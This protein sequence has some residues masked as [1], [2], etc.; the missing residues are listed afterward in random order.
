MPAI[1]LPIFDQSLFQQP[2]EAQVKQ[3]GEFIMRYR[4][5]LE[6]L[7]NGRLD[8][9]NGLSGTV[10]VN[11]LITNNLVT[12]TLYANGKAYIAELTVDQIDTSDMVKRY[13]LPVGH[14]LRLA[15]VGYWRGY[16]QFIEFL[17]AQIPDPDNLVEVQVRDRQDRLVYWLD[18]DHIGTGITYENTGLPVMRFVY[19]GPNGVGLLKLAIFHRWNADTKTFNP[20][21]RLGAGTGVGNNGTCEIEKKTDG[22]YMT[23][24]A[25]GSGALSAGKEVLLALTDNGV[26]ISPFQLEA[27]AF[28]S[29]GFSVTYSGETM[30]WTWTK[31]GAGKITSLTNED[32]T[33]PVTWG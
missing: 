32:G 13:L 3:L 15:P 7:L 26:I 10:N 8:E 12:E 1:R 17:D 25:T 24:I 33:V 6:W 16:D 19:N 29:G 28:N 31:D 11:T 2:I 14:P 18:A 27:I 30:V 21:I 20:V 22:L 5:E 9:D 4:R 23:Y